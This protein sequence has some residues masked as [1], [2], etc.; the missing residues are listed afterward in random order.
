MHQ[1]SLPRG[2]ELHELYREMTDD[3][4]L[5]EEEGRRRMARRLLDVVGVQ[6]ADG[7][8]LQVGCGHGLLLDE[9][10]RRGYEVE[11]VDLATE[12]VRHARERLGLPVREMALEDAT[13]DAVTNGR[14]YDVVV[15]VD[16]LEHLNDPVTELARLG[17]LLAPGGVLLITTPDPSSFMARLTG[18]RW[19]GF[20]TAHACLMPRRTL[21]DL[22][23][24]QGLEL[25]ADGTAV[26]SFTLG[27]WLR[28][29]GQRGDGPVARAIACAAA[30]LPR[31]MMLTA[32][33][34]DE[35]VLLARRGE[36]REPVPRLCVDRHD[37]P[38]PPSALPA[39]AAFSG[40]WS[41]RSTRL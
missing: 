11:G 6:V 33:L 37:R 38:H 24:A 18:S 8:L 34:K 41:R 32:S 28:C 12:A 9:A 5:R 7:R 20:E 23:R 1:L 15:A 16:V 39:S 19:W 27:Y 40:G 2:R 14:R 17:S 30:R 22:I 36:T 21:C 25:A 29:L 3:E 31:W 26:H 10:R 35:L 4:Y 13:L